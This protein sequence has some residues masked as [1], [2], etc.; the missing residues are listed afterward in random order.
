MNKIEGQ[1]IN[2]IVHKSPATRAQCRW[3]KVQI[4]IQ[5]KFDIRGA[6]DQCLAA[7]PLVEAAFRSG[8]DKKYDTPIHGR[9][10]N[11]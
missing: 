8:F 6:V 9:K 4:K 7:V 3:P 2:P 1:C 10:G 11:H 5:P